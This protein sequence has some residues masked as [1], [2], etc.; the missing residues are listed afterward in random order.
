MALVVLT[1]FL[2]T[3]SP[4]GPFASNRVFRLK[5]TTKTVSKV[6]IIKTK[7]TTT[8]FFLFSSLFLFLLSFSFVAVIVELLGLKKHA[9]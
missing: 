1:G 6:A 4:N 2:K 5:T 9:L 8:A 3:S 7:R